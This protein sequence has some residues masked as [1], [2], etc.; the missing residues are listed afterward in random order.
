MSGLVNKRLNNSNAVAFFNQ[1]RDES[2]AR[3]KQD[4][5]A[6]NSSKPRTAKLSRLQKQVLLIALRWHGKTWSDVYNSDIKVEVFG[7]KP[8]CHYWDGWHDEAHAQP[9]AARY[10]LDHDWANKSLH[11]QIF[12]RKS[13][14]ERRYNTVSVSAHRAL[15]RLTERHLLYK[16]GAGWSLTEHGLETAKKL[17]ASTEF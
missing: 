14:G 17:S 1:L 3:K 5:V 2:E 8:L 11:G 9:G 10:E 15:K 13:I 16:T 6:A 12:N 4:L 7:W